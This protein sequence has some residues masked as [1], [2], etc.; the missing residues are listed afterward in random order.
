MEF[1]G[2]KFVEKAF[3]SGIFHTWGSNYEEFESG[4]GNYTVAIV[5]LEDGRVVEVL[6]KDLIFTDK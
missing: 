1:V 5:E 3:A 2:G 4:P 6:P